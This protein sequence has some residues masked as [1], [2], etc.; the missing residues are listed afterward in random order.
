MKTWKNNKNKSGGILLNIG[1][2][3]ADI[4]LFIG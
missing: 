1:V 2:H 3:L 4:L